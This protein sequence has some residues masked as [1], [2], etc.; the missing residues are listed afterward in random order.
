MPRKL[1]TEPKMWMWGKK[2]NLRHIDGK[3]YGFHG[4]YT[5]SLAEKHAENLRAK[6]KF[7]RV[8]KNKKYGAYDVYV[9]G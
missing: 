6:G 7:V 9:R 5:K 2:G 3:Y 1:F 4:I 8:I